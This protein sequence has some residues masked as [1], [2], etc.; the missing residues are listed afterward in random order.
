MQN[1][2]SALGVVAMLGIAFAISENH[3]AVA[4]KK[5]GIGLAATIVTA[6]ILL[7]VPQV[8]TAFAV[9]NDGVGAIAAATRAGTSF[10][11]GYLGGAALPDGT[12]IAKTVYR[13]AGCTNQ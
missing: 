4:W 2:Q 7:K 1:L 11:F 5:A 6:V 13:A 10:V 12:L 3:R 8:A 9:I